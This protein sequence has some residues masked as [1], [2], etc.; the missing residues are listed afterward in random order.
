[1][2]EREAEYIASTV[3]SRIRP[4]ARWGDEGDA[5]PYDSKGQDLESAGNDYRAAARP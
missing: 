5:D 4:R 2:G 3:L 1:M